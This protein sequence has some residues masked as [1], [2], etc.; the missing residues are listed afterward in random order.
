MSSQVGQSIEV[1][2]G[3]T[4]V[5]NSAGDSVDTAIASIQELLHHAIAFGS[6]D[7]IMQVNE[8]N[9]L[10]QNSKSGLVECATKLHEAMGKLAHMQQSGMLP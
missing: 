1:L 6:S 3:T 7:P 5:V 4:G 8:I 9:E 2:N 10:V